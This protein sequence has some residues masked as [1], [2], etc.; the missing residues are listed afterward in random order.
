[1]NFSA[2]GLPVLAFR[3][4]SPKSARAQVRITANLVHQIQAGSASPSTFAVHLE[5]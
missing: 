1:M 4:S 2:Y 5:E 3:L